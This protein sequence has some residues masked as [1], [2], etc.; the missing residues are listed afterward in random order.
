MASPP[1]KPAISNVA[2]GISPKN[3]KFI[4]KIN[5]KLI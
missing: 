3:N 2:A 1:R 5:K 4:N